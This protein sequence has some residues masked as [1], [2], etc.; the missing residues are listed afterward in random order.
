MPHGPVVALAAEL[1]ADPDRLDRRRP[2]PPS[3]RRPDRRT[4]LVQALW[5]FASRAGLDQPVVARDRLTGTDPRND[6]FSPVFG[7]RPGH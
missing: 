5:A 3:H 4:R 2:A 7:L 6:P 1:L